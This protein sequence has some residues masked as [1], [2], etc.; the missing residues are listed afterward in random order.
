[1]REKNILDKNVYCPVANK[2]K[3]STLEGTCKSST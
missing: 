2:K 3:E 1:M